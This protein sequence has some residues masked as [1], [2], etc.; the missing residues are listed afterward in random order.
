VTVPRVATLSTWTAAA[1]ALLTGAPSVGY[2]QTVGYTGSLSFVGG[3][4]PTASVDAAYIF[5]SVDVTGGPIRAAVTVPLMRV[6]ST[7]TADLTGTAAPPSTTT[8]FGDPLVRVDFTV[9]EDRARGYQFTVAG[10]AKLPMVDAETGRGTGEADYAFGGSAFA[11]IGRT[12]LMADVL[13]WKYGDPEGVDF[14]DTLSYSLGVARTIG[15]GRWSLFSSIGGFSSGFAGSPPPLALN[16]GLLTLVGGHQS[17]AITA[18]VGLNDSSGDFSI[19][20]SW[21]IGR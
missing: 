14:E 8:G 17:L 3:T 15:T 19:G 5:N 13:F 4:Y 21:R 6:E 7:P 20:T 2:A 9:T 10:A 12:S 1:L 11:A 18:S 16:V